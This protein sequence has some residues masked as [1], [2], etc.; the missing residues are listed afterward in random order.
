MPWHLPVMCGCSS[1]Q[2]CECCWVT[3][4][5]HVIFPGNAFI[6]PRIFFCNVKHT[7]LHHRPLNQSRCMHT[8]LECQWLLL[9]TKTLHFSTENLVGVIPQSW[10]AHTHAQFP[11]LE[12]EYR[13]SY[14]SA[15]LLFWHRLQSVRFG[16]KI[17]LDHFPVFSPYEFSVFPPSTST[18]VF[19]L[20]NPCS[21]YLPLVRNFLSLVW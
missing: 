11:H 12:C 19:H 10:P 5:Q 7:C 2:I 3:W 4:K 18:G 8:V 9:R 21:M 14:V 15:F 1:L 6:K 13:A 16:H 17:Q 20:K